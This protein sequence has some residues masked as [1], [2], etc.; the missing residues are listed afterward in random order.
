MAI[1]DIINPEVLGRITMEKLTSILPNLVGVDT[2][3]EFTLPTPG[4]SWKIPYNKAVA[5]FTRDGEGVT[6]TPQAVGQ[7]F[8]Q[9]VVQ[10]A[11]QAY[12]LPDIDQL[13]AAYNPRAGLTMDQIIDRKIDEMAAG[14]AGQAMT[15]LTQRRIDVLEG[16][17]PS[18]NRLSVISSGTITAAYVAAAKALL[19]DKQDAL[20]YALMNSKVYIDAQKGGYISWQPAS[21]ILNLYGTQVNQLGAPAAGLVPTIG[22]MQIVVSDLAASV[23]TSPT[24]YATYLLSEYSMGFYYQRAL[25]TNFAPREELVDG[26]Y[27]TAVARMDFVMALHGASYTESTNPQVYTPA[28]LKT[29]SNWT[30]KWNQKNVGAVRLLSQ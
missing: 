5:A 19:G 3:D 21:Q 14:I 22:G 27:D 4:T 29:T 20:K 26:G 10:R 2:S 28:A 17:I 30:L 7:D 23:S 8:F 24:G 13:V 16:G 25:Q 9:S 11:A 12:K 15:Y 6:L 1:S 18:A